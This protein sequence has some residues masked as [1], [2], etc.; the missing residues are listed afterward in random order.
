MTTVEQP[1]S[2]DPRTNGVLVTPEDPRWNDARQAWN[3]AVDQRP[4]AVAFPESAEDVIAVV[5]LARERG[6][7]VAPQGTG[8]NAGAIASLDRTIL[9][10]TSRMRDVAIDPHR[11]VA[12]VEAGALWM[13]V[14]VPAAEH[15]LAALAGSSPDVGVV[16]YCLGGGISWLGRSYGLACNH[17]VAIEL[18]TAD[19]RLVRATADDEADLF[20]ALR[21]G[22]GSFG[23]VTAMEIA[24][25]PL[26][27]IFAGALFFPFERAGEV[28]QAWRAWTSTVP[29]SAMSV[30][31][32]LQ[33][34]PLPEIPEPLRGRSF[35]VIE[36]AVLADPAEGERLI[37]PLRALGAE[38]DTF[39]VIPMPALSHLHMDPEHPVPGIG[40]GTM[41]A[42]LTAEAVDAMVQVAGPG[43][44]SPLLSVE[45]RHL[46]G[47]LDRAPEGHGALG[48]L[49]G[50]YVTFGVGLPVDGE[51]TAAI[52]QRL[53]ALRA[54]FAP[55]E[56]A[57]SYLN[58]VEEPTDPSVFF[59][60]E[61][62]ARLR[63]VKATFDPTDVFCANHPIPPSG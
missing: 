15:G 41:L 9:L 11:R 47:A 22:G 28:L 59:D 18:V 48:A 36:A 27:T 55:W 54:A 4:A 19:G 39:A 50:R 42:E 13:D 25:F 23:I 10:K 8:H 46:G 17:V 1:R 52:V 40:R 26:A 7:R 37:A 58:F 32:L 24:L 43:S 29:E 62:L 6:M 34:P 45:I 61:T 21:G 56:A 30:G 3:L 44:G 33:L 38:M 57:R 49:A 31:R 60:P 14:T 63:D 16:G 5:A 35:T 20:W 51:A 12:R 53:A 2:R